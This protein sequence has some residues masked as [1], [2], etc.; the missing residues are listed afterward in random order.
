VDS[1]GSE[2]FP[3]AAFPPGLSLDRGGSAG[4][5][6]ADVA[7]KYRMHTDLERELKWQGSMREA[8]EKLG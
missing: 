2:P 7:K 6:R 4:A 8:P 1:E 3:I 5:K